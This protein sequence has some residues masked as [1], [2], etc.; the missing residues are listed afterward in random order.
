MV[1][2]HDLTIPSS[3]KCIKHDL[4]FIGGRATGIRRQIFDRVPEITRCLHAFRF[5][6][7]SATICLLIQS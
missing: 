7:V 6:R 4:A 1:Y 3:S 5:D 2:D